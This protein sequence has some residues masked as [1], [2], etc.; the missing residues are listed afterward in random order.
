MAVQTLLLN[1]FYS[2]CLWICKSA[3]PY[4]RSSC[5]CQAS[6]L[7]CTTYCWCKGDEQ[8]ANYNTITQQNTSM[9]ETDEENK[10]ADEVVDESSATVFLVTRYRSTSTHVKIISAQ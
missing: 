2:F 5:S 6:G 4:S 9:A 10:D 3:S 1:P 7:P 8:C